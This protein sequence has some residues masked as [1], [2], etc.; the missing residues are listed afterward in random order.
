MLFLTDEIFK[1]FRL[2]DKNNV[3]TSNVTNVTWIDTSVSAKPVLCR[4]RDAMSRLAYL[5]F[6][7]GFGKYKD[8][9]LDLLI[10]STGCVD[11]VSLLS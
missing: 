1:F 6:L 11:R 7:I 8:Q 5:S 2:F 10:K 4:I 3:E 9:Q